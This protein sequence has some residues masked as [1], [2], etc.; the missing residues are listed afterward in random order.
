MPRASPAYRLHLLGAF[1]IEKN[2]RA[3]RFPTR[4]VESLLAYLALFPEPHAREK[5]AALLWG[6]SSDDQARYSLR[7]AL[8]IIRKELGDD[9]LIADRE[10]AQLNPDF[11]LWVDTFPSSR[12]GMNRNPGCCP[13]SF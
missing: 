3:I 8:A 12:I 6:D 13:R 9:A 10:T 1:R 2:A 11:P 5:L 7:T 4:K